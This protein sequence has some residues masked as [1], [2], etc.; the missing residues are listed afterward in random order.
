MQNTSNTRPVEYLCNKS[1]NFRNKTGNPAAV[2]ALTGAVPAGLGP[3]QRKR[4][5]AGN[6][7]LLAD[8]ALSLDLL[9][10]AVLVLH[11]SG[12]IIHC[13]HP[14][15]VLALPVKASAMISLHTLPAAEPWAACRQLLREYR[16]RT[17]PL[18]REAH[19]PG[20]GKY[21]SLRLSALPYL[22]ILPRR[23]VLVVRDITEAVRTR[24]RLHEREV[25]AETGALL[26]GAAH[27][28]KN[29][30]FGLSATL[31]AFAAR[32]KKDG[33]EDDHIGNLRTGITRMQTLLR[34]LLDYGNPTLC[35]LEPVSMAAVLRRAAG[36]C[37]NLARKFGATFEL[38]VAEDAEVVANPARLLRAL[39]NL[40]ENALQHS[41]HAGTVK[42]RLSSAQIGERKLL[43]CDVFDQGP[44]FPPQQMEKLFTPFFTLRPA[45]TGLGLTIAKKIIEDCGGAIR[46]SNQAS[47]GAQVTVLLPVANGTASEFRNSLSESDCGPE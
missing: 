7:P 25:M 28:A 29:A 13:N 17:G 23:L 21:W 19:D 8:L 33:A 20:S 4:V 44:G 14:A 40:V 10:D 16:T 24:E 26:A 45:G 35:E 46:L 6:D 3:V 39:E 36:G 30:I 32:V 15:A 5:L 34:D 41:P 22:G 47:G 9:D 27:Q 31:D 18:E 2:G 11:E 43:R 37:Q 38:E 1:C 12:R 42:L